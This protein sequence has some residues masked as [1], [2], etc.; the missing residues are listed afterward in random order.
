[1]DDQRLSQSRPARRALSR[2]SQHCP[3]KAPD[4]KSDARLGTA[5]RTWT[6]QESPRQLSLSSHHA[7]PKD[8]H[9]L[10]RRSPG[11]CGKTYRLGRLDLCR[12]CLNTHGCSTDETRIK[13]TKRSRRLKMNRDQITSGRRRH[14]EGRVS[15][16]PICLS[17]VARD[18]FRGLNRGNSPA[19]RAET[20]RDS[21]SSSLQRFTKRSQA[22]SLLSVFNP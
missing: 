19:F 21:Q 6:Y 1:M 2:K 8:H 4:R 20:I 18:F 5:A 9:C 12:K 7:R 14:L 16:V 10:A 3:T 11:R 13:I 17:A 22:V 15:R